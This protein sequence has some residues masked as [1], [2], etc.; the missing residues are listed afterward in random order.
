MT[1]STVWPPCAVTS[2]IKDEAVT[3]YRPMLIKAENSADSGTARQRAAWEKTVRAGRSVTARVVVQGFRQLGVGSEQQ[4]PLWEINSMTEVDIPYLR[5][6]QRLL[7]SKVVFK[8]SIQSGSI[9]ELELGIPPPSRRNRK[10]RR[11]ARTA[12]AKAI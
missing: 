2:S 12:A 1:T 9:T 6:Q 4:G 11:I 5:L 3:R 7:I 8:R 10:R